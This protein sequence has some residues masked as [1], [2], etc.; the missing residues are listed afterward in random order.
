MDQTEE[1]KDEGRLPLGAGFR[2]GCLRALRVEDAPLMLEWMHDPNV[3]SYLETRFDLMGLSDCEDFIERSLA[4]E[5]SVHLA[6]AEPSTD[7]YLGTIS[8]KNVNPKNRR[9]EYAVSTRTKAHGTGIALSATRD[10]LRVAFRAIGLRSVFLDV[11]EDNPRAIRFYEKVG[12]SYEGTARDALCIG[13]EFKDLRFYSMLATD[14]AA[15]RLTG[16]AR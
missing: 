8:L 12:F 7:E 9:A 3:G 11:R 5:S 10:I 1:K 2:L 15:E 14:P 6:I 13:G 16:G 4:D